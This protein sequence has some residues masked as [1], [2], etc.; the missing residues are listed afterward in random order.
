[1]PKKKTEEKPVAAVTAVEPADIASSV[2]EKPKRKYTRKA[3]T[4]AD[5]P[6]TETRAIAAEAVKEFT[7]ST[8]KTDTKKKAAPAGMRISLKE[9]THERQQ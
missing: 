8:V 1:M 7:A 3:V 6:A 9:I 2:T 4:K 5:T